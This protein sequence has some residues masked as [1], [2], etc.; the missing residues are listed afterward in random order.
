MPAGI[1][2]A[3]ANPWFCI[4]K[5]TRF[6]AVFTLVAFDIFGISPELN[7]APTPNAML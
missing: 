7:E 1:A 5:I 2:V 6:G 4:K 3:G